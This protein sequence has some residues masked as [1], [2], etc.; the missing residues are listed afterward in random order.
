MKKR[1][2]TLL[3]GAAVVATKP[4]SAMLDDAKEGKEK[5]YSVS[6]SQVP[7][8]PKALFDE[9]VKYAL[10]ADI[11][12]LAKKLRTSK[13]DCEA[14]VHFIQTGVPNHYP[15][16]LH[17]TWARKGYVVDP[18]TVTHQPHTGYVLLAKHKDYMREYEEADYGFIHAFIVTGDG[19]YLSRNGLGPIRIFSSYRDML[20]ADGFPHGFVDDRGY[21]TESKGYPRGFVDESGRAAKYKEGMIPPNAVVGESVMFSLQDMTGSEPPQ[22]NE[23]QT[24][25]YNHKN[26]TGD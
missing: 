9:R 15:Q 7:Q 20:V 10:G 1:I 17:S 19:R 8:D 3:L 12:P 14:L 4:A 11:S 18:L 13:S 2:A 26:A 6:K 22:L 23:F 21:P 16:N 25:I 24:M 5:S